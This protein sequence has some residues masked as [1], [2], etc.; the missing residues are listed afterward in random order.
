MKSL[1]E[2]II[3]ES[4][5]NISKSQVARSIRAKKLE[6]YNEHIKP[7]VSRSRNKKRKSEEMV[8]E[9]SNESFETNL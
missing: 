3:Q 8:L 4:Q 2:S 7:K 6:T 1:H 9:Q 5:V